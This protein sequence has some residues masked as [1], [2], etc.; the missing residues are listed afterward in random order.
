MQYAYDDGPIS[1]YEPWL[2]YPKDT[3]DLIEKILD[4]TL[5]GFNLCFDHFHLCKLYT[6][7]RLL[8]LN[9]LPVNLPVLQI[10]EAERDGRDG[11]CL[12]PRGAL[13]LML[14]SRKGPHQFL[15]SR[16]EVRIR[17]IPILIAE[18]L[19][20]ELEKRIIFDPILSAKWGIYD[21]Q[22]KGIVDPEF[23]DIALKFHPDRGL[24]SLAKHCLG[25]DPEFNSFQEIYPEREYKLF[26]LG[27]IPFA[28]GASDEEWKGYSRSG[29]F[30]GYTW[31]KHIHK[32]IEHWRSNNDARRYAEDDV[33]Y[34]RL[35]D[36]YFGYPDP[37]DDDSILA[38]MVAAV[39]WHGFKIDS[40]KIKELLT[41]AE[42]LIK[43][44]PVN[45]NKPTEVRQY[46]K[47]VMDPSECLA[48]DE[49]TKKENLEKIRDKLVVEEEEICIKCM[50][51]GC[52]RCDGKGNLYPGPMLASLRAGEILKIKSAVKEADMF[53]KLLAAGRFHASFKVIGTLSSRMAGGD[54]LNAQGIKKSKEVRESFPLAW[55]GMILSG[56]D[57]ESFEVTIADAVFKDKGIRRDLLTGV[58]IHAVMATKLYSKTMEEVLASKGYADGGT[59]DMYTQGK[60]AIFGTLYGGDAGTIHRKLSIQM[61]IAEKAFNEFQVQ[62]PGVKEERD[63]NAKLFSALIQKEGIGTRIEW[64]E[65]IDY[66]ETFLGF[67]RYFTLENQVIK[68]LYILA[69]TIPAYWNLKDENGDPIKLVRSDRD[70]TIGG[71]V[72]SALYGAAFQIQSSNIRAA[73]NHLIQSP[74]AQITKAVQRAIWD[75]QPIGINEFIV[76]PM[77]VHDEVLSVTNPDYITI[78]KEVVKNKVEEYRPFVPLIGM[79]WNSGMKSWGEKIDRDDPRVYNIEPDKVKILSDMDDPDC[80]DLMTFEQD[81]DEWESEDE[82]A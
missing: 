19:R 8:P 53:K 57:F 49:S 25:L 11:P 15:M 32:D 34:T 40:E 63:R 59:I 52:P 45:V 16:N 18:V 60:R 51:A 81:L 31:P 74:G 23:K 17:K 26:E 5:I 21:R 24:K 61:K 37:N 62:Y 72:A 46:I 13:D 41:S 68:E 36:E 42:Q 67:K 80:D 75:I 39:R 70:Q 6:T 48:L 12:K 7:F 28:T 10:A 3:L 66:S 22:R 54:G 78:V 14:H 38:C 9:E 33:K 58:S 82:E 50:G 65:P 47:E 69:Q 30:K 64:N 79:Q 44:S 2:N 35:L 71:V 4:K 43:L 73:N 1:L 56:G 76:A 55:D 27:Y 29:E 77:N 20:E